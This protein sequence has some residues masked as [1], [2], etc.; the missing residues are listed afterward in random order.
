MKIDLPDD[1]PHQTLVEMLSAYGM[2]LEG[3]VNRDGVHRAF[4]FTG[5]PT[6]QAPGCERLAVFTIERKLFCPL[7][8]LE[9]SGRMTGC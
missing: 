7:H 4:R 3:N 2:R 8:T 9:I 5:K 1:M 6:C